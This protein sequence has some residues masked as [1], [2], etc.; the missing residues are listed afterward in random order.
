MAVRSLLFRDW[1]NMPARADAA[2]KFRRFIVRLAGQVQR[3]IRERKLPPRSYGMKEEPSNCRGGR[4]HAIHDHCKGD[5]GF[6]GGGHARG[7]PHGPDGDV[8]RGIGESRRP[9]RRLRTSGKLPRVA[10]SLPGRQCSRVARAGP[11]RGWREFVERVARAIGASI[12]TAAVERDGTV[13]VTCSGPDL[14]LLDR[15]ARPDDRRDPVSGQRDRARGWRGARDRRRRGGLPRASHGVPRGG[16]TAIGS[17][18]GGDAESRRPRSDDRGR[19]EDRPRGPEGRPRGR[20]G[21]RG[22]RAEPVRRRPAS[23]RRGVA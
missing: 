4:Y 15:E 9:G 10:D 19:A 13:T 14:G 2:R 22:L 6:G 5:Q 18:C 12:S 11:G 3:D 20:D 16:G 21:E 1:A 23:P 8:P 17:T 7:D